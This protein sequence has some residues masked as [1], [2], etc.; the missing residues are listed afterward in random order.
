V[1][2]RWLFEPLNAVALRAI[3]GKVPSPPNPLG[4][5]RPTRR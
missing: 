5:P 1:R 4:A 3:G 2:T